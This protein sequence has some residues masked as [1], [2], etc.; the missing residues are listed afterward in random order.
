MGILTP[1]RPFSLLLHK[2]ELWSIDLYD[3]DDVSYLNIETVLL[4]G[5][6]DHM[7]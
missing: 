1:W 6:A 3:D 4:S 2:T 7:F 5:F